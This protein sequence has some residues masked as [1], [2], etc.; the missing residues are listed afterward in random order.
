MNI[1]LI[2]VLSVKNYVKMLE[3]NTNGCKIDVTNKIGSLVS[4]S[5][6]YF[7][8]YTRYHSAVYKFSHLQ[9]YTMN[10]KYDSEMPWCVQ[11]TNKPLHRLP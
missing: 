9:H 11:P 4:C 6:F 2:F 8:L 1:E 7:E 10:Y 3:K 5:I